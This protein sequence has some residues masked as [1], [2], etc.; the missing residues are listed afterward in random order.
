MDHQDKTID[1]SEVQFSPTIRLFDPNG[2]VFFW[3]NSVY[4]GIYPHRVEFI[5]KL[6]DNSMIK[7]LMDQGLI[8]GTY[9]TNNQLEGFGI[10][11]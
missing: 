2:R 11:A 6:F 3:K 1:I 8:V 10:P 4:R 9:Q 5:R 7:K